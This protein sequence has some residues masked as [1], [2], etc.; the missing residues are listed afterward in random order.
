MFM[1]QRVAASHREYTSSDI[2][3]VGLGSIMT[4]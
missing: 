1:M 3:Q 4:A 2:R